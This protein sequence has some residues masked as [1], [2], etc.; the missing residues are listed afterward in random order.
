[1]RVVLQRSSLTVCGALCLTVC[2]LLASAGCESLI[3]LKDR[4]FEPADGGGSVVPTD[5]PSDK[6]CQQYCDLI[7]GADG[8]VGACSAVYPSTSACRAVCKTLKHGDLEAD[9]RDPLVPNTYACRL[10]YARLAQTDATQCLAAGPGGQD[11]CGSNC[12]SYCA[13]YAASGC[14]ELAEVKMLAQPDAKD[15]VACETKCKAG[16]RD[17]RQLDSANGRDHEGNTVQCRL[18]HLSNVLSYKGMTSWADHCQHS[19]FAAKTLCVDELTKPISDAYCTDYCLLVKGAC[20]G[21]QR[22]YE[23]DA[24]CMSVCKAT[25]PGTDSKSS[26]GNTMAC[27]L[28]HAYN[29]LL[30]SETHCGHAGAGGW[31]AP[32]CGDE[33]AS[34]CHLAA[35]ACGAAFA[36]KYPGGEPECNTKCAEL[37]TLEP[38]GYGGYTVATGTAA[39]NMGDSLQCRL[40]YAV[41]ALETPAESATSCLSALGAGSCAPR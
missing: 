33:C 18:V 7:M 24:Q 39:I 11:R 12:E 37:R 27:R 4:H 13:M 36:Q 9:Q 38:A 28:Y 14:G 25:E 1:L 8:G 3:D 31:D 19:A 5:V 2:L 29:A 41:K 10:H 21:A 40:Y 6:E 34:Y 26:S 20:T 30:T 15:P 23:N 35:G 32:H 22:L 16:L 17:N